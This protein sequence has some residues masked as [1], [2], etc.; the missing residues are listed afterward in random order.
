MLFELRP[1]SL[2]RDGLVP[3]LRLYLEHTAR[4]T[5][6]RTEVHDALS[7]DV[8][9]D[10]RAVLY[11]IVQEAVLNARKHADATS[12][13]IEVVSAAQGVMVR[14]RDDG[15]GFTPEPDA[16]PEPG[17]LGLS[18]MVERAELAGGWVRIR[19]APGQGSLV[20][21]WLPLDVRGDQGLP[22]G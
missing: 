16:V 21:C 12:V 2:D 13:E 10:L 7:D 11:R 19:S 5:G 3:A 9:P 15:I 18:T 22:E 14:I 17:H 8:D 4:A 1:A 6:W 20:E